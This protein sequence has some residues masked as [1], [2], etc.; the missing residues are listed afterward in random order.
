MTTAIAP[1]LRA[2]LIATGRWNI[3]GI[4]RTARTR[5]CHDCNALTLAGLDD[6]RCAG[7]AITDTTPLSPLGEAI[8]H[9]EGRSTYALTRTANQLTLDHRN[10]WTIAAHPAGTGQADILAEHRCGTTPPPPPLCTP[11]RIRPP[12]HQENHHGQDA[13]F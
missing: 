3:D 1:W 7:P 4:N 8:A 6:P 11:S 13:P 5:T 12:T 9:I 10:Q 2:H